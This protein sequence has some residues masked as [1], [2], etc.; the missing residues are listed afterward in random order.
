MLYFLLDCQ[1]KLMLFPT[2]VSVLKH[3]LL[4]FPKRKSFY[5]QEKFDFFIENF[6]QQKFLVV[7]VSSFTLR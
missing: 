7:F 1:K 6:S 2:P 4:F 3:I 5:L